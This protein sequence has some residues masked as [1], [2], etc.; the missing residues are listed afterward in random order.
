MLRIVFLVLLWVVIINGSCKSAQVNNSDSIKIDSVMNIYF[1]I[2]EKTL[3]EEE[4]EYYDDWVDVPE[5]NEVL[6]L[7]TGIGSES[8]GTFFGTI[9]I[10]Q[11][12]YDK[13][14]EWYKDNK[15]LLIWEKDKKRINRKDK[16]VYLFVKE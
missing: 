12:T 1:T 15:N 2:L 11:A 7:L 9:E 3:K 10:T 6:T 14:Y 8:D 5:A 13:W 4:H 16:D